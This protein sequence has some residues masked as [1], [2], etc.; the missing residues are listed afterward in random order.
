MWVSTSMHKALPKQRPLPTHQQGRGGE[1]RGGREAACFK[2]IRSA[3]VSKFN[4]SSHTLRK[5]KEGGG[6]ESIFD[7]KKRI[8][9][10]F[11]HFSPSA[12][13]GICWQC[14]QPTLRH[15]GNDIQHLD[16]AGRDVARGE[17]CGRGTQGNNKGEARDHVCLSTRACAPAWW[18]NNSSC[19]DT[20]GFREKGGGG[21][22]WRCAFSGLAA[23]ASRGVH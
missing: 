5:G 13:E 17:Q 6:D 21:W 2:H 9:I 22:G 15:S 19:M 3:D 10:I 14:S 16:R 11:L 1:E 20:D 18:Q 12:W 7:D 8:Y 4:T 23:P